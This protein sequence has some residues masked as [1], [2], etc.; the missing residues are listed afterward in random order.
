[1]AAKHVVL[2]DAQLLAV[3][4]S[5]NVKVKWGTNVFFLNKDHDIK[6]ISQINFAKMAGHGSSRL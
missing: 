6:M 2:H 5:L 1:M 4:H 3:S